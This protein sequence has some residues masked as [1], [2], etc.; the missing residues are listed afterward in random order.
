M[1]AGRL[2]RLRASS[3][4]ALG[5][6][7][8]KPAHRKLRSMRIAAAALHECVGHGALVR[9]PHKSL[10]I[11]APPSPHSTDADPSGGV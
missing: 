1:R 2:H 10:D 8:T 9:V 5:R 11:V 3:S 7:W 4:D 6:C